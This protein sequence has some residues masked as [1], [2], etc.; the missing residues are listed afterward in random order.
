MKGKVSFWT[1]RT[2]TAHSLLRSFASCGMQSPTP[3]FTARSAKLRSSTRSRPYPTVDVSRSPPFECSVCGKVVRR[4]D[5][6]R[7]EESHLDDSQRA[8][9][10]CPYAPCTHR[11]SKWHRGNI[12]S[13]VRSK[14]THE[15]LECT[16]C[17][18]LGRRWS[19]SQNSE[20]SRHFKEHHSGVVTP[21]CPRPAM[22]EFWL[23]EQGV[24]LPGEAK[25]SMTGPIATSSS[26]TSDSSQPLGRDSL[27]PSL[28]TPP[29]LPS[30]HEGDAHFQVPSFASVPSSLSLTQDF[31]PDLSPYSPTGG[32]PTSSLDALLDASAWSALETSFSP[33]PFESSEATLFIPPTSGFSE[34]YLGSYGQGKSVDFSTSGFQD[35]A[36][37]AWIWSQTVPQ[38]GPNDPF[39]FF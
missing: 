16:E 1:L 29:L 33:L 24:A 28:G 23:V 35:T 31:F 8:W 22:P 36:P 4:R 3:E 25:S 6:A 11:V 21:Y 19:T 32:L 7:H 38:D 39:T 13:H 12:Y 15:L 10:F 37:L 20:F 18:K 5:K 14:H 9:I 27:T 34:F 17:P 2:S 26:A 30:L